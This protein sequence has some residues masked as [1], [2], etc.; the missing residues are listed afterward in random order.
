MKK[1]AL[2][3]F[4]GT[5]L[6]LSN[7]Q[8]YSIPAA[9]PRQVIDQQ[10][11]ISKI[12]VDY[13]RP[14]VKGRKIFGDL[15]PYGKVWRAGANSCTKISFG[16]NVIFGGKELKAGT[17]GLYIIPQPNQ[18]QVVL[19]KDFQS[20]GAFSFDEKLNV[21]ETVIPVEITKTPTEWFTIDFLPNGK[22]GMLM[23][24]AWENAKIS[25]P[26]KVSNPEVVSKIEEKLGEARKI[27]REG[28][29]N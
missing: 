19:N 12:T 21:L 1:A 2:I 26:I 10:F 15:V 24:I 28:N 22:E 6:S 7:A 29:K 9:S 11:S 4:V 14:G 3:V 25:V 5:F 13:G 17:Y 27:E 16:Q 8:T 23:L 20:W 18:W